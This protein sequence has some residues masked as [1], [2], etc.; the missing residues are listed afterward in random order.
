MLDLVVLVA[1]VACA[2]AAGLRALAAVDATPR[3]PRDRLL[4]GVLVGLG[5]TSMLGLGFA[6]TGVLRP[7]PLVGAGMIA[8]ASGGRRLVSAIRALRRPRGAAAWMSFAVCAVVVLAELPA[9]LAPPVGGDQT[10]YAL[11][12]PRLYADAGALVPTPWTYWGQQQLLDGFVSA[13]AFTLRG[14]V[15]ARLL[16]LLVAVLAAAS[17]A[18]VAR[19]QLG[20][21]TGLAVAAVFLALPM[22]CAL[23]LRVGPG[24]ALVAYAALAVCAVL[25]WTRSERAGDLVRAAL[26][27]G[28]AGATSVLGLLVPMFLGLLVVSIMIERGWTVGRFFVAVVTTS[29][30]VVTTACPWYARNALEMGDPFHPYGSAVFAARHWSTAASTYLAEQREQHRSGDVDQSENVVREVVVRPWDL[31]MAPAAPRAAHDVG[32]FAL[33]FLPALVLLRRRRERALVVTSTALVL[34]AATTWSEPRAALPGIALAMAV[35]VPAARALCGPRLVVA[36]LAATVSA[37]LATAVPA[38]RRM[39]MDQVRT[40]VG[41]MT[42]DT[43]LRQWSAR[44]RFWARAN[45]AIPPG[46]VVALVEKT[47]HPYYVER[48]FVLL[49]HLE[50]G[51]VDYRRVDTVDALSDALASLRVEWIAV[52]AAGVEAAGDPYEASVTRLWRAFLTA[53]AD[54]VLRADGYALYRLRP[55][56][57]VAW[58]AESADILDVAWGHALRGAQ[59]LSVVCDPGTTRLHPKVLF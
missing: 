55:L 28:L 25:D 3:A 46:E 47:P 48:P 36:V 13:V 17:L 39:W 19:R 38:D 1:V 31:T 53:R 57:A 44:Y 12:Y 15:L 10:W 54:V 18:T 34:I 35:A 56:T 40:S 43:F 49:S 20:A 30:I 14:D 26:L 16:H 59:G 29:L 32:P 41:R 50:Q 11:V 5:L 23:V 2:G 24:L 9:L 51:L 33:A 7:L 52:D 58:N 6:A 8:L 22:T 27:A 4:A 45:A 37:E 42:P 21:G